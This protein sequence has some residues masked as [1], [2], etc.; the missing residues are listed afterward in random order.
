M[1]TSRLIT[2]LILSGVMVAFGS[3]VYAQGPGPG[4]GGQ[5]GP[6]PEMSEEAAALLQTLKSQKAAMHEEIRALL[7][8]DPDATEE[9]RQALILK[10]RAENQDRIQAQRD[11]AAEIRQSLGSDFRAA[12]QERMQNKERE[13]THSP[14]ARRLDA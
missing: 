7:A 1:R 9:E 12:L 6:G 8:A 2:A 3:L 13:G 4:P 5:S 11:L 10:W 14:K